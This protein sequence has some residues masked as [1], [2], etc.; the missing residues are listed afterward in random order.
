MYLLL[1]KIVRLLLPARLYT[2]LLPV[3]HLLLVYGGAIRYGFPTRNIRVVGVTG[4]KGKSS[5]CELVNGVL[6][7]A[8]YRTALAST[9]RFKIGNESKPNKQKMTMPGRFFLQRFF[10]QAVR[11]KCDWVV[12]EMTSEGVK[13][14]RHRAIALDALIFTN[15]KPEHI[16]S[17]GSFEKYVAAKLQI[18]EALQRSRK[19]PRVMIANKDDERGIL[20][21]SLDVDQAR[22]YSLKEH[23]WSTS[24]NGTTLVYD[25]TTIQS[26]FP[27]D[28]TASNMLAAATFATAFG[29]AT[30]DIKEGLESVTLIPGRVEEIHMG[31]KF[32]VIVDYAHTPDSLEKLYGAFAQRN[33]IC[34]LGNTGGGRDTWKRPKMA[35]LAEQYCMEVIL[36]DEDP[37]DE[38]PLAI[39]Q[40]MAAGMST[41]PTICMDRREAIKRALISASRIPES[42]VLITG[43]GTD[44]Y[45]MR[46]DG[47]KEPWSDSRVAT[48]E[49]ELLLSGE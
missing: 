35:A 13:Q 33:K 19:R 31:Q 36:T 41:K 48:E 17:H 14:F 3:W 7:A 11:E 37:Y 34:V 38:D 32:P 26:P 44:P 24:E 30:E 5:V 18:G 1:K 20:F 28:F 21:A 16:E 49:L 10:Y 29:I 23:A 4:T 8:G 42:A 27:G 2:R 12:V 39:V 9:I 46:A 25:D 47:A 22:T 40:D 45:I 43:K 6:E 15:L